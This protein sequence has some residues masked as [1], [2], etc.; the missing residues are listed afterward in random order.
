MNN[1]NYSITELIKNNNCNINKLLNDFSQDIKEDNDNL[2]ALELNYS[3][4]YTIKLLKQ[5]LDYYNICYKNMLKLEMIQIL[6]LFENDKNNKE[7]VEK[8]KKLWNNI[9]ELKE[10]KYFS[11]Y[12]L[13]TPF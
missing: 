8:R 4:N 7:L 5:I 2:I 12:I 6:V 3:T 13:F 9:K 1:L 11:K 10:D